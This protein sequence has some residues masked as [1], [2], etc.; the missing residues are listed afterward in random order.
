MLTLFEEFKEYIVTGFISLITGI[1]AYVTGRRRTEAD[2]KQAEGS[3]LE[4]IQAVYD[5]FAADTKV[6]ID[7]LN[8]EISN[9]TGRVK[10]LSTDVQNLEV[11]LEDCK[12]KLTTN[13]VITA[14]TKR[15]YSKKDK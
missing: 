1:I 11:E 3:A 13:N 14:P 5:K 15:S 6:K 2:T 10:V 4:T 9:L 12:K 8:S 7:E